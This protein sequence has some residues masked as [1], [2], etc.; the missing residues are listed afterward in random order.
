MTVIIKILH[1]SMELCGSF[2][3]ISEL[4]FLANKR[5]QIDECCGG[6]SLGENSLQIVRNCFLQPIMWPP[7]KRLFVLPTLCSICYP[8]SIFQLHVCVLVHHATTA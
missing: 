6:E 8:P 2:K 1:L 5:V 7:V 3:L 4:Y